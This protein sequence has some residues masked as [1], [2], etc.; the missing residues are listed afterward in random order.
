MAEKKNYDEKQQLEQIGSRLQQHESTKPAAYESRWQQQI[1]DAVDRILNRKA[2]SYDLNEDAI[3][4]TYRDSYQRQGQL[5]MQDAVGR[6]AAM[7]GGYGNSYAQTAG[8]QAYAGQMEKLQ[9]L[10]PELYSLALQRYRMEGDSLND[11]LSILQQQENQDY[12]RHQ[13]DV[14]DW[15]QEQ[16]RLADSYRDAYGRYES[17]RDFGY[18]QERDQIADRQWQAEFDEA[19]RQF[20]DK[21]WS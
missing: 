17:D 16:Q 20:Y 11:N 21:L 6:A 10:I 1:G 4:R 2:F 14:S 13:D 18:R 8:A 7:T 5:V 15:Q 19:V 3:F 12:S 9:D